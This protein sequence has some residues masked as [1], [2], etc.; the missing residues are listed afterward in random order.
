MVGVVRLKQNLMIDKS[1]DQ[2]IK[3]LVLAHADN[4]MKAIAVIFINGEGEPEME[5]AFGGNHLYQICASLDIIKYNI[6]KMMMDDGAKKPKER[7]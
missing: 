7:E 3:R 5:I 1:I 2:V 6:L 4:E